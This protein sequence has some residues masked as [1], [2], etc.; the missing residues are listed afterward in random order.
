M[1]AVQPNAPLPKWW[2]PDSVRCVHPQDGASYRIIL[3]DR[4][5]QVAGFDHGGRAERS[6]TDGAAN[7]IH[8]PFELDRV[9]WRVRSSTLREADEA[10]CL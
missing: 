2:R 7:P 5:F 1:V 10:L 4:S 9:L 3:D 8:H 6:G